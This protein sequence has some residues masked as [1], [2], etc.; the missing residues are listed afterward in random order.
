[1][2]TYTG[3]LSFALS[4]ILMVAL[5]WLVQKTRLGQSMRAVSENKQAAALMGIDVDAVI[6]K[7]FIISGVLA[8]AAGINV[9]YP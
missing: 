5:F 9:G 6:S 7:T 4:I 3:V 2:V 8:G 1:M